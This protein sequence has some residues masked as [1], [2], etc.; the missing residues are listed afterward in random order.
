[1]SR[2]TCHMSGVTC[3]TKTKL[4]TKLDKVVELIGG[5]FV[6]N[7]ATTSSLAN[8]QILITVFPY[9]SIQESRPKCKTQIFGL[10]SRFFKSFDHTNVGLGMNKH[11]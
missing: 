4:N 11:I 9:S 8:I 5:G 3:H 7:G 6:I 2:V 10:D 1:M